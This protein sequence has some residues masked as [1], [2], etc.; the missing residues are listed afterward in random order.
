MINKKTKTA[1]QFILGGIMV[2]TF[3][4][5]GCNNGSD[6]KDAKTDTMAVEKMQTMPAKVDTPA[7]KVDSPATKMDKAEERPIVPGN[8]PAANK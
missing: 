6:T 1:F 8:K 3:A 5:T 2:V 4:T 7:V